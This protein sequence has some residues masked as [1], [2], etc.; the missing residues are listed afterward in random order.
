MSDQQLAT[1]E[2]ALFDGATANGFTEEPRI[3]G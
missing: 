2:R 1:V 3:W